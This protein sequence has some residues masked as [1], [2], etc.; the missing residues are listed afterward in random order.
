MKGT[1]G[2]PCDADALGYCR[3]V[4][5]REARNFYY[6][7][8]LLPEPQRSAL[9]C[10]YAWMRHAD[11]LAD[12]EAGRSDP[13]SAAAALARFR[14]DTRRTLSGETP[15][16]DP[17]WRAFAATTD[18]FELELSPF[19]DMID[20]QVADLDFRQPDTLD[21]LLDYCRMV[22]S[23]VGRVCIAIWGYDDPDAPV[24][25]DQRGVAFQLTNVL[26][27]IREDH[28]ND[29][30]YLPRSIFEEFDLDMESLLGWNNPGQ[31][32]RLI[33]KM[34]AATDAQYRSS[35]ALDAMITSS[36]RPTLRAMTRI[37]HGLLRR[38]ERNPR[39]VVG[40]RRVRLGG[41]RKLSIALTARMQAGVS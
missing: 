36:C 23:S 7:L 8:K 14:D 32:D 22:A 3:D 13:V 4:T 29:R 41:L 39:S 34:T 21:E 31:C 25:A 10:I 33:R 27:D 18:R 30:I 1:T 12:D 28:G 11:D 35:A 16:D 37:Y 2:I 38:I 17:M 24:L 40:A 26:R 9:F 15:S 20:G 5:R 6:G 19:E